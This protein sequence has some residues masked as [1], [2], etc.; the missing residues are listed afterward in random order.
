MTAELAEQVLAREGRHSLSVRRA[1]SLTELRSERL[2]DEHDSRSCITVFDAGSF[3][4]GEALEASDPLPEDWSVTTDS[5][6]AEIAW[7]W[8]ADELVLFKS[9]AHPAPGDWTRAADEGAVDQAFPPR[10]ARLPYV[11][12]VDLRTNYGV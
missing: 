4:L 12:W 7:L 10:A 8:P 5:I 2:G 3:L 1:A 9:C 6:A 11:T